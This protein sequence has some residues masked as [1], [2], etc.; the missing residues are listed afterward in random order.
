MSRVFF[1]DK[2]Y[3]A[4]GGARLAEEQSEEMPNGEGVASGSATSQKRFYYFFALST[5]SMVVVETTMSS[6]ASMKSGI[7][8][9][10]PF[11][12]SAGLNDALTV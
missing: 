1:V 2:V 3:G 8:I 4:R 10:R 12:K 6:P 5:Y 7:L 11:V 9:V